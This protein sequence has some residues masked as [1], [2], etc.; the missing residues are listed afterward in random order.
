MASGNLV[1]V[2][3]RQLEIFG[4]ASWGNTASTQRFAADKNGDKISRELLTEADREEHKEP[5]LPVNEAVLNAKCQGV[6]LQEMWQLQGVALKGPLME[7]IKAPLKH[8]KRD[9]QCCSQPC[10]GSETALKVQGSHKNNP[11]LGEVFH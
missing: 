9:C 5:P 8:L 2:M 10:V 4:A 7:R 11:V 6:C 3:S 1:S